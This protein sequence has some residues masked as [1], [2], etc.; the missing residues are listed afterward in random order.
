MSPPAVTPSRA[1]CSEPTAS[2][3]TPVSS[4]HSSTSTW[5]GRSE[6]PIPRLS[7]R[8]TREND[9]NRRTSRPDRAS[10]H[11]SRCET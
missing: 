10:H 3:T 5:G 11:V 4:T 8:I 6:S 1:A 7:K 2:S 9:A